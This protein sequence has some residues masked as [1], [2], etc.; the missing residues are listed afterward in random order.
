[1]TS[2]DYTR[3]PADY[4]INSNYSYSSRERDTDKHGGKIKDPYVR[5]RVCSRYA[6]IS[7]IYHVSVL[8]TV[9]F[10]MAFTLQYIHIYVYRVFLRGA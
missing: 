2:S 7:Y 1:M 9:I 3:Q 6:I 5:A 8:Q 4:D 10:Q